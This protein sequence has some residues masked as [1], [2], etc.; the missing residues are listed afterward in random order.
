MKYQGIGISG[1]IASGKTTAAR[2]LGGRLNWPVVSLASA[3]KGDVA[4]AM[5][6]AGLAVESPEDL[7]KLHK[8]S[9]RS[10][11][12]EW[13]GL[14]RELNGENYWI[15]RLFSR[16][17]EPFIVDDVRYPNEFTEL[18]AR[19]FYMLRL[20]AWP[21]ERIQRIHNLYPEMQERQQQHA[22]ETALDSWVYKFNAV[23]L[24]DETM[25]Q[26]LDFIVKEILTNG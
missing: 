20:E 8:A 5:Y 3:L 17:Q 18:Q 10:T 13:G 25:Y 11:L 15:Q 1:K 12:Q 23:V 22:S 16:Q 7:M 19:G 14:F 6:E 4:R 2:Y 21:Q 24:S 9:I 26:Q